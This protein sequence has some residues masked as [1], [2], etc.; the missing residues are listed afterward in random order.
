[1]AE[2]EVAAGDHLLVGVVLRLLCIILMHCL[3][4][5]HS[6][7]LDRVWLEEDGWA[8]AHLLFVLVVGP[9]LFVLSSVLVVLGVSSVGGGALGSQ[10]VQEKS[11][12]LYTR[13][14][15]RL[16]QGIVLLM[17]QLQ[18]VHTIGMRVIVIATMPIK[19]AEVAR[20]HH[21]DIS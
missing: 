13:I 8:H 3:V 9:W 16:V 10:H 21:G 14:D 12:R 18:V 1:M 19:V 6:L 11:G 15:D 17:W 20:L 2:D 4:H 7:V 5:L